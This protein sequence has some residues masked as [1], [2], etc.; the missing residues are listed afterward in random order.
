[1]FAA[2]ALVGGGVEIAVGSVGEMAWPK[3]PAMEGRD[4][5]VRATMV[6]LLERGRGLG[7]VWTFCSCESGCFLI[8]DAGRARDGA[9]LG[10]AMA[11][12]AL[13][14]LTLLFPGTVMEPREASEARRLGVVGRACG[15]PSLVMGRPLDSADAGLRGGGME[16]SALKKLDLRLLLLP[17]GEEGSWDRLSTVLSESEGRAFLTGLRASASPAWSSTKGYSCSWSWSSSLNPAREL[18]REDA[19]DAERNPSRS[20]NTSSPDV[21]LGARVGGGIVRDWREVGRPIGFLKGCAIELVG[22]GWVVVGT[23][24]MRLFVDRDALLELEVV[25]VAAGAAVR[26]REVRDDFFCS[27]AGLASDETDGFLRSCSVDGGERSWGWLPVDRSTGSRD[28]GRGMP[29]RT[30]RA[31]GC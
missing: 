6:L 18:A 22:R 4:L 15:V 21:V 5:G 24:E 20:P 17:A 23:A 28:V 11:L 2:T 12:V 8:K 25:V 19:R 13:A 16:P 27:E 9:L 26:G 31:E 7:V 3:V 14:A 30:G 10:V 29:D 1:M